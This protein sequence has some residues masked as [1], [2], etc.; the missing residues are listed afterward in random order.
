M[1][2]RPDKS[3]FMTDDMRRFFHQMIRAARRRFLH[4]AF[5]EVD[6]VKAATYLSFDYHQKRLVFNSGIGDGSFNR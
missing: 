3:D 2:S 1:K 5:L 4:L 6:G